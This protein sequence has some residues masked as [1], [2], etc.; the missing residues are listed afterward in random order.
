MGQLFMNHNYRRQFRGIDACLSVHY[1]L[2]LFVLT[3][4]TASASAQNTQ[5]Q[6]CTASEAGSRQLGPGEV[7]KHNL[8]AK[9][10][11][12]FRVMLSPGQYMHALVNQ[13]GIDVVV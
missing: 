1:C 11:H 5:E 9:E 6:G 2:A 4:L 10:T 8:Q 3:I 13:T 12:V 7:V